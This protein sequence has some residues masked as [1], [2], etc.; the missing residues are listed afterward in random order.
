[1]APSIHKLAIPSPTSGGRS[2]GIVR[3][4]TQ[5]TEFSSFFFLEE[6]SLSHTEV[7]E[8]HARFNAGRASIKTNSP[9]SPS[10][11][12]TVARLQQLAR[13][14]R[15]R[16]IQDLADEI[17]IG[18]GTCQRILTTEVGRYRFTAQFEPRILAADRKHQG[19]NVYKG[20]RQ[21]AYEDSSFLT[22]VSTG[23]LS[24]IYGNEPEA[25]Q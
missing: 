15:S 4:R 12:D 11:P 18:Y 24:W 3:S 6:E 17:A 16:I 8:W 14:D 19:V 21:I 5:T 10:T 25:K 20:L 7:F 13:G 2:V 1:V 9:I 22:R 23:E